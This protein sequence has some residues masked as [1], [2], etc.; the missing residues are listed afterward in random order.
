MKSE[1]KKLLIMQDQEVQF[2]WYTK[3]ATYISVRIMLLQKNK[4]ITSAVS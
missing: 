4:I 3:S 2:Y 1:I